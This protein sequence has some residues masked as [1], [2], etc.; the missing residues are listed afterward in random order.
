[1]LME[2]G[3]KDGFMGMMNMLQPGGNAMLP[4]LGNWTTLP[5]DWA[6]FDKG[7]KEEMKTLPDWVGHTDA[8]CVAYRDH[9]LIEVLKLHKKI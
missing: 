8:E 3:N 9:A 6:E 2:I 4:G 1:M 7:V 5:E